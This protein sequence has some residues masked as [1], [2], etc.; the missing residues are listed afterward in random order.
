[1]TSLD[2][3]I[4]ALM[5]VLPFAVGIA[6]LLLPRKYLRPWGPVLAALTLGGMVCLL[7][8]FRNVPHPYH[9]LTIFPFAIGW[10][11]AAFLLPLRARQGYRPLST[12]CRH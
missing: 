1:M 8:A 2:F 3:L 6:P 4:L 11:L 12:R 7:A 9:Q 10:L 5:V